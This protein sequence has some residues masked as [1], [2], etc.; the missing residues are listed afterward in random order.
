MP[1]ETKQLDSGATVIL[2]SGRLVLGRE[3]QTMESTVSGL[4]AQGARKF[5]IDLGALDYADSSGIGTFVSCLT[6]IKKAGGEMRVAGANPRVAKL[7]E[8]TGVD[9]LMPMY[10]SV[11]EAGA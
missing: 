7:F 6:Q 9:H 3:V 11:A 10:A 1:I 2:L 5:I 4:V 8:L